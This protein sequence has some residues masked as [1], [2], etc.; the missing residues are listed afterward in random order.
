MRLP[1]KV[2]TYQE[3]IIS[4]F[5]SILMFI[6]SEDKTVISVYLKLRKGKWEDLSIGTFIQVLDS[7]MYLG[8]I[9]LKEDRIHYVG[10]N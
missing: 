9:E 1:N 4:L 5:P 10:R 6:E 8:K 3:S 7:L 2:T